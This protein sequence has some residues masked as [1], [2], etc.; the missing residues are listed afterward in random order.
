MA[1]EGFLV[2]RAWKRDAHMHTWKFW[3][4]VCAHITTNACTYIHITCIQQML[5]HTYNKCL[6]IHTHFL[7]GCNNPL[8]YIPTHYAKLGEA[9]ATPTMPKKRINK[10]C[11]WRRPM[12]HSQCH[13]YEYMIYIYTYIYI[14][15][16]IYTYNHD[17]D[18]MYTYKH[19]CSHTAQ[20][21]IIQKL[22]DDI[23]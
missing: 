2:Q 10:L 13:D 22:G 14:Y 3:A 6:H 11:G 20:N 19:M 1:S 5:A 7:D 8:P 18:Y 21:A 16:Y 9:S 12:P 4:F 23:M 15:A 17:I